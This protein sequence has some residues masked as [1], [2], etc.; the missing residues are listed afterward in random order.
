MYTYSMFQT[1]SFNG[2]VDDP[3]AFLFSHRPVNFI[4]ESLDR[5]AFVVIANPAF[6]YHQRTA[7]VISHGIFSC[8]CIN[9][10]TTDRELHP[11]ATGGKNNT[12]S[13]SF[14][15]LSQP[16]ISSLMATSVNPDYVRQFAGHTT[17]TETLNVYSGFWPSD[18][19]DARSALSAALNRDRGATRAK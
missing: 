1:I 15:K 19:E 11:P 9:R 10:G 13:P 2:L 17:L 16:A 6:K 18:A 4:F 3:P 8:I 14:S 5:L 7:T 12:T